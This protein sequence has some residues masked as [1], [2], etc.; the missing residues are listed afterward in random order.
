MGND[1]KRL[2]TSLSPILLR[3]VTDVITLGIYRTYAYFGSWL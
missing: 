1:G 3:I 2:L